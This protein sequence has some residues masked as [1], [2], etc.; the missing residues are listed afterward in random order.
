MDVWTYRAIDNG[1]IDV[2]YY[3]QWTY[4]IV[5]IMGLWTYR[6]IDNGRMDV[7]YD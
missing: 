4:S 3:C 5:A 6:A 1:H 7:L 2:L